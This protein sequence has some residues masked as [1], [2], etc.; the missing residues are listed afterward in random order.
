M[1]SFEDG[2]GRNPEKQ[3]KPWH[4]SYGGREFLMLL[5]V[6]D[7]MEAGMKDREAMKAA[8]AMEATDAWLGKPWK[9]WKQAVEGC[10]GRQGSHTT[11]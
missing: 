7:A 2:K 9:Q 10:Y 1:C 5:A 8:A 3:P 4:G 6:I 11:I